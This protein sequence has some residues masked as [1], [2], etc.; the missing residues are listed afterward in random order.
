[1]ENL[2]AK[3]WEKFGRLDVVIANAGVINFGNTWELTDEQVEK[4]INID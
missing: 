3:A 2:F 4:V 1:M